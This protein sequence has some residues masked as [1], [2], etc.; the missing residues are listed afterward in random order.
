MRRV[1]R[2]SG[3]LLAALVL[4]AGGG[5]LW[6]RAK[7]A[8]SLPLTAGEHRLHGLAAPLVIQRD[9]LGVPTIRGASR[10]D[11]AR[12]LGFL[13]AQER[14]FQMDLQRRLAAVS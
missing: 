14:F 3:I 10:V 7:L 9:A 11:V 6:L 5:G 13:H 4:A 1:L 8:A 12:G 2:A